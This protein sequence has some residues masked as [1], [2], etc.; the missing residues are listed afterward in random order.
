MRNKFFAIKSLA[1]AAALFLFANGC[2]KE[3]PETLTGQ[4]RDAG[5]VVYSFFDDSRFQQSDQPGQQWIWEKKGAT[6]QFYGNP[7]RAWVLLYLGRDSVRAIETDT[8][9]IIRL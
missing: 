6:V 5:G 7:D 1:I 9:A 4:W 3:Q 2:A 8:F